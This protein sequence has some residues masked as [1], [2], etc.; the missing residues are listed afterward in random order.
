MKDVK[1]NIKGEYIF[2]P[3]VDADFKQSVL[4]LIPK[5][6]RNRTNIAVY[7]L[8]N[9]SKPRYAEH[10]GLRPF[11]PASLGKFV[12]ALGVLGQLKAIYPES[13]DKRLKILK[14]YEYRV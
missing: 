6:H 5:Q 1:L 9:L 3:P 7:D 8:T 4:N 13:T 11:I 12:T 14:K 2:I 10:N